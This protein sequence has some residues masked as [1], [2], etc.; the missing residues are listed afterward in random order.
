MTRERGQSNLGPEKALE[1]ARRVFLSAPRPTFGHFRLHARAQKLVAARRDQ[2]PSSVAIREEAE[3]WRHRQ[4]PPAQV[5]VP[6]YL[7]SNYSAPCLP[8][9]QRRQGSAVFAPEYGGSSEQTAHPSLRGKSP[10]APSSYCLVG[11]LLRIPEESE[12]PLVHIMQ[13]EPASRRARLPPA[14]SGVVDGQRG[15]KPPA[16][17]AGPAG[18]V[19]VLYDTV[20][21]QVVGV[22]N[23]TWGTVYFWMPRPDVRHACSMMQI[24][25]S[26]SR[27]YFH[28]RSGCSE[29]LPPP[30]G[31]YLCNVSPQ[32]AP[33]LVRKCVCECF[34]SRRLSTYGS[35]RA[36]WCVPQQHTPRRRL[37]ARMWL[38]SQ[39]VSAAPREHSVRR[40]LDVQFT[41]STLFRQRFGARAW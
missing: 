40:C 8:P 18:L 36:A 35:V 21:Q 12:M 34:A 30:A 38:S 31:G 33:K 4:E 5:P 2:Q 29:G 16:G 1:A 39:A 28:I 10:P 27:P 11:D 19:F 17:P 7:F 6:K 9:F 14:A 26:A 37:L 20:D 23:H 41:S 25:T 32:E 13:R 15:V 22:P 24:A 3:P